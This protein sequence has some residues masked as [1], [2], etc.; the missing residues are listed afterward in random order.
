MPLN[1]QVN[2]FR[3]QSSAH[4]IPYYTL[5]VSWDAPVNSEKFDLQHFK[6][7]IMLPEQ[8]SYILNGTSM[9]PEYHVCPDMIQNDIRVTITTVSKCSQQGLS[10]RSPRIVNEWREDTDKI[11]FTKVPDTVRNTEKAFNDYY[12]SGMNGKLKI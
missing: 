12:N 10:Y 9:E 11:V 7:H 4:P 8:E 3:V 5:F 1:V 6:V 2:K